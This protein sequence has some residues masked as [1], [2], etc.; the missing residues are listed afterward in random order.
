MT[1]CSCGS[2][3][4][5]GRAGLHLVGIIPRIILPGMPA[6]P[7]GGPSW[8][9]E[10]STL[11]YPGP[12]ASSGSCAKVGADQGADPAW[13]LSLTAWLR[14]AKEEGGTIFLGSYFCHSKRPT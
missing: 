10:Q 14:G 6:C 8:T 9:G 1:L 12:K 3:L 2:N 13:P 7:R 5:A 4:E 11:A